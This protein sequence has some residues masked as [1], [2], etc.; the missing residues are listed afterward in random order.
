[1]NK[2]KHS[3]ASISAGEDLRIA[4]WG[5]SR[6]SVLVLDELAREGFTPSLIV[7]APP[8]P[9]G[10]GLILTSSD[11]KVWADAHNVSTL[12]PT[13]IKSEKFLEALANDWDLFIIA[14]YG[15]IVPRS[16][17]DLPKHG[18]LNV[19]PSLLPKLRGATPL[20]S[21]ILEDVPVGEPHTTGVSVMLIDE[22]VDHGPIVAQETAT[23]SNWPPKENEL[24]E[25]LGALGG[26]LLAKTI[27]SWIA[28]N[29]TPIEQNHSH[30]TYTK[31]ITKTDA[32][33]NL[34]EDPFQT[35]RKIRAFNVWPRTY[36]MTTRGGREM[37][38]VISEAHIENGSLVIDR[39]IPEG[40]REMPYADF[41]RAIK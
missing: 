39:V 2:P 28:G 8:K 7:T 20:Q 10:R 1:M 41:L 40:K 6:F 18:T 35:Y 19:H 36:F 37:R 31:K 34:D 38:V 21:A 15:K 26:A 32:L 17:L 4:F 27:P 11:V 14:S 22:E 5:T 30:A 12:E 9:K 29:I 24:E 25:T 3:D 23:I 13:E 33:V 16:I